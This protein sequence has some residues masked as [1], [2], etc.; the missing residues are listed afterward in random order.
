V[1]PEHVYTLSSVS[2]LRL[3][4]DGS[5]LA[6]CVSEVDRERDGYRRALWLAEAEGAR[7]AVLWTA[8]GRVDCPRWSPDGSRIAFLAGDP[9]GV[10]RLCCAAPTAEAEPAVLATG[11]TAFAW[12][13]DG[14]WLAFV[15]SADESARDDHAPRVVRRAYYRADGRG[16]VGD[17]V[18][19]LFVVSS[20]G[21]PARALARDVAFDQA[22]AWS[23][24]GARIAFA[25]RRSS[26]LDHAQADLWGV[27]L[28]GGAPTRIS[29]S[30]PCA[31]APAW[32]PDGRTLACFGAEPETLGVHGPIVRVWLVDPS[33]ARSPRPAAPGYDGCAMLPRAGMLAAPVWDGEGRSLT[34][35]AADR[36]DIHVVR[37]DA[38]SGRVATVVGGERQVF[39]AHACAGARR[40][41][42]VVS[43]PLGPGDLTVCDWD[44]ARER[45]WVA[46]GGV[47]RDAAADLVVER[48]SFAVDGASLDGWLYRSR[49]HAGPRPLALSV[50]GGP[51]AF[52]GS[53]IAVS[54]FYRYVLAARGWAVLALN[55][56]GSVSYGEAFARRIVGC[57]GERDLPEHLCAIDALVDERIADRE[58]LAI[59]GYSY[60]GFVA[61]WAIGQTDRFRAAVIGAP[62]TDL[63][64]YFG[65]S[66]IGPWFCNWGMEGDVEA[67]RERYERLSPVHYA[68]RATT[69]ALI[70]H[71]EADERCPIGQSEELFARLVQHGR[72]AV[73]FV[74]YP[75]AA[76]GFPSSGRPSH[77]VDYVTRIADWLQRH[78]AEGATENRR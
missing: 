37:A 35:S 24:D 64:S 59:V 54:H 69:P 5:R 40:I 58:R 13:P 73:E 10:I 51:H 9:G 46:F 61:A 50:H 52:V 19:T 18:H 22:P 27:A 33:G 4:P 29:T 47:F 38:A 67:R 65:T 1:T 53:G 42:C 77:R 7:C 56:S 66:D 28:A 55:A 16:F 25:R 68:H 63:T 12:S 72:S 43:D 32:S 48:R 2:D 39:L 6:Y 78:A 60:G 21:G 8:D 34:F 70:L 14:R 3:S 44:G 41:A 26:A 36:G 76:H 23:P 31:T 74:R 20:E 49:T 15:A 30:V 71:G 45:R 62:I 11:A 17:E 75:G 57:W